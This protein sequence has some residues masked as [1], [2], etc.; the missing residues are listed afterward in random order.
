MSLLPRHPVAQGFRAVDKV[1]VVSTL[2]LLIIGFLA[3]YSATSFPGTREHGLHIKQLAW[4]ALGVGAFVLGA[5]VPVRFYDGPLALLLYVVS[6]LGIGVTLVLGRAHLGATR[7]IELGPLHFQPSEVAKIGT[8]LLLARLLSGRP[9][10][11]IRTKRLFLCLGVCAIPAALV[12][13]Q[14]DLGTAVSFLALPLPLMLWAG[15]P[16]FG[17]LL[18]ASP[19]ANLLALIS[20]K[21]WIA[22]VAVLALVLW[23][24]RDRMGIFVAGLL[25]LINIGAGL[26]APRAWN[27]LHDYQKQRITT[28]LD[29]SKDPYGAGYQIIQSKIALGSGGASG[30]GYLQG[31]Q[32]RLSFLPE[33]HTDFIFCVVGEE[34]GFAGTSTILLL[35]T[36]LLT[37]GV[38][39]AYQARNKFASV[40]ALGIVGVLLY[41][42]LVNI[43]MTVGLAP[44]TGLPL[45]LISYGGSSLMTTLFEIGLLAN[46]SIRRHDY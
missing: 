39:I 21:A 14:P 4:I 30:K 19:V 20:V 9:H 46:V 18:V 29:P 31:T 36:L 33:Q 43:W 27:H 6:L 37:N 35:F 23:N 45:P 32:K 15:F 7:W 28:F 3:V 34:L 1:L 10:D 12:M 17:L 16:L 26:A 13:K 25:L 24:S 11:T 40:V 5:L 2:L 41:N 38:L 44:V 8:V 42:I 22:Y